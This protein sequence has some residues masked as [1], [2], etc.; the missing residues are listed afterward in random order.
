MYAE[1]SGGLI[2]NLKQIK[3]YIA[4]NQNALILWTAALDGLEA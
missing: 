1:F 4:I 2:M 3:I